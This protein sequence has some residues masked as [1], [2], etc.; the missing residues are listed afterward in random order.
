MASKVARHGELHQRLTCYYGFAE[1]ARHRDAWDLLREL[2]DISSLS[3]CII[4]DFNDL[5][6][7]QHKAGI[8]HHPNWL[9]ISF[10]EAIDDCALSDIKS[11]GTNRVLEEILDMAMG[12]FEWMQRFS[13][14][15]LTNLLASHSDHTLILLVIVPGDRQRTILKRWWWMVGGGIMGLE[16]GDRVVNCSTKLQSWGRRKSVRFKEEINQCVHILEELRAQLNVSKLCID[17]GRTA[18]LQEEMCN[19]AQ[20]YFEQLF[21]VN[22]GVHE[23]VLDLMSQCVSWDDNIMLT[24]PVTKEELRQA[25]FRCTRTSPHVHMVLTL[26]FFRDTDMCVVMIFI[27][28]WFLGW[29]AITFLQT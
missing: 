26:Y 11:P 16:H 22:A 18:T 28:Q 25:L 29:T 23:P 3:W 14:V 15:K 24:T 12:N 1:R 10:R 20:G 17:D 9:C 13:E 21:S 19:V 27:R 4:G 5:L 6:S 7:Q 8:H 2:R